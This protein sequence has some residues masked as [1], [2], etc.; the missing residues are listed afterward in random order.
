M[1]QVRILAP[2]AQYTGYSKG[3]LGMIRRLK[4]MKNFNM[5]VRPIANHVADGLPDEDKAMLTNTPSFTRLGVLIGY[6]THVTSLGTN[7]KVIYSMYEANNL[8]GEWKTEISYAD[9]VWVP[10]TF[11]AN[12]FSKHNPKTRI[13]PWGYNDDLYKR[14]RKRKQTDIFEFASVG[15]M[16]PRKGVDVLVRSFIAAFPDEEDVRLTIKTRD[17]RWIPKTDD[18]RIVV[19]DK[20]YTDEQMLE[21]YRSTDCLVQPSRG[22][23]FG[24]PQIEA[25]AVGTPVLTTRW[26]G[27]V[28]YIDDNGIWGIDVKKLVRATHVKADYALWAE[29]DWVHLTEMMQWMYNERPIVRG[30]Y[31]KWALS[32]TTKVFA[33][34]VRDAWRRCRA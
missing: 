34:A 27:P 23:G 21:L 24:A 32:E 19:I 1:S 29:P 15:V 33:S 31:K 25:A 17:T 9:E 28:D 2:F 10:S 14:A 13:V 3:A 26:G 16:S 6:P 20:D 8:P 12:V 5:E 18:D 7:Y 30:K 11:C 22:E 4:K